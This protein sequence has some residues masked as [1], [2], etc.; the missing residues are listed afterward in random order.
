MIKVANQD[1]LI[2]NVA[3]FAAG[4]AGRNV[5]T[6]FKPQANNEVKIYAL[7]ANIT[8]VVEVWLQVRRCG[9]QCS[10]NCWSAHSF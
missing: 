10:T 7:L 1:P 4:A 6:T 3:D 8:M 2:Y 5:V 9:F